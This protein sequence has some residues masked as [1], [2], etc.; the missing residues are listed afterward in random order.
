MSASTWV[1]QVLSRAWYKYRYVVCIMY[2]VYL[3]MVN[4]Y[5]YWLHW[6]VNCRWYHIYAYIINFSPWLM[7]P[8]N[9]QT[10]FRLPFGRT[11]TSIRIC[12]SLFHC[13][14][15]I[16]FDFIVRLKADWINFFFFRF[17]RVT[18]SYLCH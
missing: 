1:S 11:L 10:V 18:G 12:M 2:Y 3:R 6:R 7:W 17:D 15:L 8:P 16:I 5:L 9:S 4:R 14:A 13:L